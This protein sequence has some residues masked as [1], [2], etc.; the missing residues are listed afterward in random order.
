MTDIAKHYFVSLLLTY[1]KLYVLFWFHS[2]TCDTCSRNQHNKS[3][4]FSKFLLPVVHT[5]YVSKENFWCRKFWNVGESDLEDE[6]AE[7][8]AIIIASIVAKGRLKL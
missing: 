4:P 6:F 7:A 8:A 5:I 3:T 2:Y 1:V